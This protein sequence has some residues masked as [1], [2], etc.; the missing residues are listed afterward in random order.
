MNNIIKIIKSFENLVVLNDVTET[1][2]NEI[3]KT[4]RRISWILV[5]TFNHFNGA[6]NDFSS[7]KR[8]K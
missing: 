6:T 1:V 5:S 4:R 3:K 7:G 8:H 2:K